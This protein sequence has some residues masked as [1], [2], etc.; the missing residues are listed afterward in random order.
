MLGAARARLLPGFGVLARFT[1]LPPSPSPPRPA[2][3]GTGGDPGVTR[4]G[5]RWDHERS[6]ASAQARE[7]ST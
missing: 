3:Y 2:T 7:R 4:H 6:A 1:A 5:D